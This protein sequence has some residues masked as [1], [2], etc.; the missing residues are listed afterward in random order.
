MT[1]KAHIHPP[2]R[3]VAL[4]A[5]PRSSPGAFGVADRRTQGRP[6]VLGPPRNTSAGKEPCPPRCA[7]RVLTLPER[8][9]AA[10]RPGGPRPGLAPGR[11]PGAEQPLHSHLLAN[12]HPVPS[13]F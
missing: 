11:Q 10:P 13:T 5:P 3:Q 7:H 12:N 9:R 6:A 4:P 8:A 1:S 2:T